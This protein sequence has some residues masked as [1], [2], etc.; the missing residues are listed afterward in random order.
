MVNMLNSS[1]DEDQ[2]KRDEAQLYAMQQQMDELRR[3]LKENLARQQWFEELYKQSEGKVTQLQLAQ[4]RMA[5]DVAQALHARQMDEGRVKAQVAELAQKVEAPD[6]QLREIRSQ[7]SALTEGRKTDHDVDM[8]GQQ[9]TEE[10]QRQIREINAHIAKVGDAQKQL[11]DLIHDLDSKLGE[12]R[13]EALHVGELQTMEEQRL[14]RQGVELQTLFEALR[15]QFT[16][17]SAKSQRV[18][19]VRR[20]L[21]ERLEAVEDQVALVRNNETGIDTEIAR[22]E[23]QATEQYLLQQERL[24]TARTQLDSQIGEMRQVNDQRTD[25]VMSRFSGVDDRLRAVEQTLAEL[26]S[27]FEALERKDEMIG[28]EADTIEEWLVMRQLAAMETVLDEV[29]KRRAERGMARKPTK[30]GDA[31]ESA[32]GSVYNPSGLLKSVRDAR[33]PARND[34]GDEGSGI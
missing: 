12:I 15:Q 11:R 10:M 16:E 5:Q 8:A 25:R 2:R 4:D 14:R 31:A 26:P 34:A 20:Q 29:R 27:R 6:K 7:I 23:K 19:D 33:P 18:D 24:E 32:P 17:V 9:Q 21:T 30:A 28:S 13:Q 3:Q 1:R 22:I